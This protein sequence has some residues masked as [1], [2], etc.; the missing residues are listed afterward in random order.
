MSYTVRLLA[1]A[2]AGTGGVTG[3]TIPLTHKYLGSNTKQQRINKEE[4]VKQFLSDKYCYT[5]VKSKLGDQI[6]VCQANTKRG[7]LLFYLL[8]ETQEYSFKERI[9]TLTTFAGF[10]EVTT[11]MNL[12]YRDINATSTLSGFEK[13]NGLENLNGIP[14]SCVCKSFEEGKGFWDEGKVFMLCE[15]NIKKEVTKFEFPSPKQP[16]S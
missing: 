14:L 11:T 1:L 3:I 8:S 15:G 10:N 2:L 9:K 6:I 12:Q 5:L 4:Q 16:L 7:D 13:D